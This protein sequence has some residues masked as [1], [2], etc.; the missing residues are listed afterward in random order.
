MSK[1]FRLI[2]SSLLLIALLVVVGGC[3]DSDGGDDGGGPVQLFFG[4]HNIRE[5]MPITVDVNLLAANAVVAEQG[6]G[7][8]DC[9]LDAALA[10]DGCTG[11]FAL[12]NGGSTLRAV[13]DGC[14]VPP[15]TSL[16][17]CGF[18]TG[19]AAALT[20]DS[21]AICDCVGEPLCDL[22]LFCDPTPAIC[23]SQDPDPDSCE[24]CSNGQD[25][26]GDGFVDC[27][28]AHCFIVDCGW[29]QT[30]ITC[31]STST[32]TTTTTAP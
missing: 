32:T 29:G 27:E 31:S 18:D 3:D 5:C 14:D 12:V 15:E 2:R 24:D 1:S 25:D 9:A 11:Q 22:N 28:D 20:S 4:T 26:D 8:L 10:G 23:V 7:S 30:T 21:T 13:I 17:E 6:D 16:F 19:D